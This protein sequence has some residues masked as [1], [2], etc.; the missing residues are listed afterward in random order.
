MDRFGVVFRAS[1]V[2][3][4]FLKSLYQ[5][6]LNQNILWRKFQI[7]NPKKRTTNLEFKP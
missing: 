5:N 4:L 7:L 6:S 2:S 1:P 3:H